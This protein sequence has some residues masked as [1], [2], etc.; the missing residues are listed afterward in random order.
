MTLSEPVKVVIRESLAQ[1]RT[2]YREARV[3][4][5]IAGPFGSQVWVALRSLQTPSFL[6]YPRMLMHPKTIE[7][8]NDPDG[9]GSWLRVF[10]EADDRFRELEAWELYHVRRNERVSV[11]AWWASA[12]VLLAATGGS[13]AL[14]FDTLGYVLL[15]V[16]TTMSIASLFGLL[17]GHAIEMAVV[18]NCRNGFETVV[19]EL[20]ERLWTAMDQ[21]AEDCSGRKMEK[22]TR[23][24]LA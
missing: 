12:C 21:G 14:R 22:A 1:I 8:Y 20:P 15:T 24:R 5:I 19:R 9:E 13:L 6:A 3:A 11:I 17:F 10:G 23:L 2:R 18:R 7:A 4:A 16:L